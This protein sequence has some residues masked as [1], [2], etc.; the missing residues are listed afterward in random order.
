MIEISGI[1][2]VIFD[3]D[4]T[5]V[6]SNLDF[7][8]I[9]AELKCA[10]SQDVLDYVETLPCSKQ[11]AE[12]HRV[13]LAH[14]LAD[15]HNAEW[16]SGAQT[17]VEQLHQTGM[18]MAIVTRNCHAASSIKIQNN[19]IPIDF[20]LTREDAAPKPDPEALLIVA[21]D[22]R[23]EP[24]ELLYVGDYIYDEQAAKNAGMQF[25]YSPFGRDT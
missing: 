11:R 14:E 13:I 19:A 22:W 10:P 18:P 9:K 16:L 21:K 23:L 3:L 1:R 15:A 5:L 8:A 17:F 24:A 7:A 12:A 25:C 6:E 2:G 20:I 4:G